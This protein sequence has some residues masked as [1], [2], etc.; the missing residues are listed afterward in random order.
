VGK[1][2]NGEQKRANRKTRNE[3]ER[4][5][6]RRKKNRQ[7][8]EVGRRAEG[9]PTE[10]TEDQKRK[11]PTISGVSKTRKRSNSAKTGKLQPKGK[12]GGGGGVEKRGVCQKVGQRIRSQGRGLDVKKKGK[13]KVNPN[14][15]KKHLKRRRQAEND[16]ST[17][18]K[19][20][21]GRGSRKEKERSP[22]G[23]ILERVAVSQRGKIRKR[24]EKT[25]QRKRKE[26][27]RGG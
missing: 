16:T 3:V 2:S 20:V 14:G 11:G 10:K 7:L 21:D 5:G 15:E 17:R 6:K 13:G 23:W 22:G 18:E 4:N 27:E 25:S 24:D 9:P 8:K 19:L 26:K 1:H 12:N